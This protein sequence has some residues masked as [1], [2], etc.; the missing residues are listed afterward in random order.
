M[1]DFIFTHWFDNYRG[2]GDIDRKF[3]I[4]RR[5]GKWTHFDYYGEDELLELLRRKCAKQN[6]FYVIVNN[7][8]TRCQLTYEAHPLHMFTSGYTRNDINSMLKYNFKKFSWSVPHIE[9]VRRII[10]TTPVTVA[11]AGRIRTILSTEKN[12]AH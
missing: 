6:N 4:M 9:V 5:R 10:A 2:K 7:V 11:F 12:V 1:W 3:K 8:S